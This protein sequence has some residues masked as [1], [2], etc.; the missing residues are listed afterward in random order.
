MLLVQLTWNA[1]AAAPGNSAELKATIVAQETAALESFK[2]HDKTLYQQLCLPRFNE[3]TSD[4]SIST[5]EDEFLEQD[6]YVPGRYEM[7]DV[8]VTLL[9]NNV[10]LI[11]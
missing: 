5:L 11:R 2:N 7:E 8:V 6:D 1:C 9:S 10:A 3:I 4:G